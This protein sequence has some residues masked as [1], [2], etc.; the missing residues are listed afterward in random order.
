[1]NVYDGPGLVLGAGELEQE[2]VLAFMKLTF[3]WW[4]LTPSTLRYIM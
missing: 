1:M 4:N 2:E 3:S